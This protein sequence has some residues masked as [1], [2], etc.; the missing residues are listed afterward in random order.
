LRQHGRQQQRIK[1][2]G[3]RLAARRRLQSAEGHG[4]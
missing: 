1:Q 2:P 3:C 4:P